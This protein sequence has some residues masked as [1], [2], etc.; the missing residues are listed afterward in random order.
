MIDVIDDKSLT[1]GTIFNCAYCAS[2]PNSETLGIV[3]T[4]R[5]DI[6]NKDKV[7][8]YNFIPAIPF[9]VW[10]NKDLLP[11]IRKKYLSQLENQLLTLI[12]KAGF[13][14]ANLNTF[15]YKKIYDF[16]VTNKKL[17]QKEVTQLETVQ[18]KISCLCDNFCY[19]TL[20]SN[21][22]EEIKKELN[23]I[24]QNKNSDYFFIDN[25]VG[26][27]AVIVNLREIYE[28]EISVAYKIPN[29]IELDDGNMHPGLNLNVPNKF[30]SIVGQLKSP[31][32]ELLL[33]RF[34]NNFVRI[35]I[36]N[37]HPNLSSLIM[38]VEK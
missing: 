2:Y 38:E 22:A 24:I 8:F 25:I 21:F 28:L 1:Q 15:G 19:Q 33:Q 31:F 3:I 32:I 5:C 17:K 4:A 30:C 37:A 27:N 26:Y 29:G 12:S 23:D 34:A 7:K 16:I 35:G 14:K 18:R 36:D 10:R 6:A 20:H 13:S 9:E 11:I